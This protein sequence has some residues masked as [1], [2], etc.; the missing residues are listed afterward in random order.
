MN[1]LMAVYRR[2]TARRAVQYIEGLSKLLGGVALIGV[3]VL[4]AVWVLATRVV[5]TESYALVFVEILAI[6]VVVSVVI[7]VGGRLAMD[8]GAILD[9]LERHQLSWERFVSLV[10]GHSSPG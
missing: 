1:D 4:G 3:T 7:A 9:R 5:G 6:S 2:R 8:G 10:Q